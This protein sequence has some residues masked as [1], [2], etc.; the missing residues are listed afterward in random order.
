VRV[1]LTMVM[2][3]YLKLLCALGRRNSNGVVVGCL[4]EQFALA[5][6]KCA[7]HPESNSAVHDYG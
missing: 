1:G 7:V 4:S 2:L 3:V 5:K 6:R